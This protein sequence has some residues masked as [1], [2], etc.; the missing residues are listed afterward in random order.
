[1]AAKTKKMGSKRDK[2]PTPSS[3]KWVVGRKITRRDRE[4]CL[5]PDSPVAIPKCALSYVMVDG[6]INF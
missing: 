6:V 5:H 3:V 1:M 2:G 4:G